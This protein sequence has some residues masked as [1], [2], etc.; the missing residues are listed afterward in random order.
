[1]AF[2][3]DEMNQILRVGCSGFYYKNWKGVFYPE[4][5]PS[6]KWFGFYSSK[7][8]SL[9]LNSTFYHAPSLKT[10]NGWYD[11]SP[12]EFLFSVKAPKLITHIKKFNE[13]AEMLDDFYMVCKEGLK[14]KLGCILFQLPPSFRFSNERLQ[15][16]I[17][18][19]KPGFKNVV[20]FRHESWWQE[21]VFKKLGEHK[22]TFCSVNHP[23]LPASIIVNTSRVYIRLHGNP[24]MFYSSYSVKQLKEM[25]KPVIENPKIKEAYF[26][27]N[28]TAGTA[29]FLNAQELLQIAKTFRKD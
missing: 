17:Y 11:K 2:Y 22:I 13:C 18:N 28:N 14:Q 3:V 10:M 7:F 25:Y 12:D 5:M 9:E 21:P 26:Y 24:V 19:L 4:G 6:T 23:S 27:F 16:I 8:N 1:L 29:G 15:Q 20:E